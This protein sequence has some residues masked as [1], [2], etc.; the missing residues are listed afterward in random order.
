MKAFTYPENHQVFLV[1]ER[2]T[3]DAQI[4][5]FLG[6]AYDKL[7][8]EDEARAWYQKAAEQDFN[9]KGSKDFRYWTGLALKK[10]GRKAEA[11]KL[12]KQMIKEG[13]AR[14][15]TQYVNFYGAEGTTGSTVDQINS[16][17]YF[18]QALGHKGLGHNW[19]GNRLL[20]KVKS[21]KPDHLYANELLK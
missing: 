13:E 7:G 1:D 9:L 20:K 10:L 16:G 12:F 5:Y 3:H 18:T 4:H 6:E 11:K 19:R 2:A 21:L 17:A 14:I 8:K 15:V